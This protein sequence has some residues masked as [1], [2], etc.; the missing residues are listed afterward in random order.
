MIRALALAAA[1]LAPAAH[2]GEWRPLDPSQTLVIET[3]KGPIVVEM[4]PDFAPLPV[5]RI[6]LLAREG[7]SDGLL[8]H[9]VVDHFVDQTGNPNNKEAGF[10]ATLTSR[11]NSPSA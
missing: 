2:A 10:R 9:R 6:K 8:F 11:R 5:E 4:R 1:L 7:V 3:T